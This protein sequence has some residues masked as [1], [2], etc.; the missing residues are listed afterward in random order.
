MEIEEKVNP[1]T[2]KSS[3]QR[4]LSRTEKICKLRECGAIAGMVTLLMTQQ[5]NRAQNIVCTTNWI[6]ELDF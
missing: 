4:Y 5:K 3:F 6:P 2:E 1:G